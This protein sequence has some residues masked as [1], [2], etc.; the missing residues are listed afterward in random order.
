MPSDTVLRRAIDRIADR[1]TTD[2]AARMSST[3][4]LGVARA[5]IE[6]AY[7]DVIVVYGDASSAFAAGWYD[8][9]RAERGISGSYR[10][11]MADL[12]STDRARALASWSL[13]PMVADPTQWDAVALRVQ[14][15]LDRDVKGM[16]RRTVTQSAVDDPAAAGWQRV[17]GPGETC[18]FCLMLISRGAVYSESTA[19]FAAHDHCNCQATPAWKGRPVPVRPFVPPARPVSDAQRAQLR[20][21]LADQGERL[22]TTERAWLT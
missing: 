8:E 7:R 17:A 4:S 3:K 14:A 19:T 16:A 13:T 1:A 2:I 11:S 15:G 5:Q 12:P 10:A 21:Y 18:L 6:A 20:Q 22:T 9:L